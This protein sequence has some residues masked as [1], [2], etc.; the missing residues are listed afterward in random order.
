MPAPKGHPPYPGCETGGRPLE[1]TPARIE[2]LRLELEEWMK[3]PSNF[4]FADFT[5]DRGLHKDILPKLSKMDEKFKGTYKKAIQNQESRLLKG[6]LFNATNCT[7]SIFAL[8][9]N[10]AW[11]EGTNRTGLEEEVDTKSTRALGEI[12]EMAID[13]T[14]SLEQTGSKSSAS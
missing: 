11:G 6:G 4:W 9:C 14:N 13:H 3:V 12:K 5:F 8:K 7:M 1:W 10:H 2:A